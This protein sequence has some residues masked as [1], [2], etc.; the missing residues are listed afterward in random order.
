MSQKLTWS[1]SLWSFPNNFRSWP[2]LSR[3]VDK[4][5]EGSGCHSVQHSQLFIE[6]VLFSSLRWTGDSQGT[7]G[8]RKCVWG[9][10]LE[11][12]RCSRKSWQQNNWLVLGFLHL[13]CPV[14]I[15]WN[16]SLGA[17]PASSSSWQAREGALSAPLCQ[18]QGVWSSDKRHFWKLL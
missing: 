14:G 9:S 2:K 7:A 13:C 17:L 5:P 8:N 6:W 16:S 1:L 12:S 10:K 4:S 11:K 15:Q 3:G 18:P